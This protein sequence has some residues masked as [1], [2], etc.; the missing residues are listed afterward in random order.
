MDVHYIASHY[1]D[2]HGNNLQGCDE[3]HYV[4]GVYHNDNGPAII[5]KNGDKF[6]YNNGKVHRIDGAAIEFEDGPK[7]W[8]YEGKEVGDSDLGYT[9]KD[10]DNWLKFKTFI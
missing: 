5:F 6:W 3:C 1:L 8:F 7:R 2:E 4:N 10:F 9:Q